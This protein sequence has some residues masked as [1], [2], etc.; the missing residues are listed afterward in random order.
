LSRPSAYLLNTEAVKPGSTLVWDCAT[1]RDVVIKYPRLADNALLTTFDY[2][3]LYRAIHIS[4]TCHSAQQRL[5]HALANLAT[6][7]G[8]KVV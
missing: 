6:G 5:A 2:L 8:Q 4:M 3:V 7:I 1:I